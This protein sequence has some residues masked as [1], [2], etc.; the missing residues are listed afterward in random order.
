VDINQT[1]RYQLARGINNGLHRF[2]DP[3]DLRNLA[4]DDKHIA[5]F[6]NA[7]GRVNHPPIF[8]QKLMSHDL[9]PFARRHDL[10]SSALTDSVARSALLPETVEN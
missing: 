4:V 7:V 9:S 3:P 8:Y 5:R 6:V 2:V 1:G 10:I